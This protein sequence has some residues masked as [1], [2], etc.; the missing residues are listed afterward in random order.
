M[1]SPDPW[2]AP[3]ELPATTTPDQNQ[4]LPISIHPVELPVPHEH[5][6]D[7]QSPE[8]LA[9][10]TKKSGGR[11]SGFDRFFPKKSL[12]WLVIG[13]LSWLAG[14]WVEDSAHFILSQFQIHWALGILF[15]LLVL[16]TLT[17]A[18]IVVITEGAGIVRLRRFDAVQQ[19]MR[20]LWNGAGHGRGVDLTLQLRRDFVQ[21]TWL[22]PAWL[23]FHGLAQ[24]HHDDRELLQLLS[25]TVYAKLDHRCYEIIVQ[26]GSATALFSTLSPFVWLDSLF[27][28]WQNLK[29]I[30]EIAACYGLQPGWSASLILAKKVTLGLFMAGTVDLVA[31]KVAETVGG[32]AASVLLAQVGKGM[33]NALF[34]ARVGLAAMNRCRMVP[35]HPGGQPSLDHLRVELLKTVKISLGRSNQEQGPDAMFQPFEK[36]RE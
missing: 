32:Q 6:V 28:L 17:A 29:M 14:I 33:A 35:F 26:H 4:E 11:Y 3:V 36:N 13:G 9:P 25:R 24:A 30:R 19:D 20:Q 7:W 2:Q 22:E 21:E 15:G 12:A 31:D 23:E 16:T 18:L 1:N 5:T 27:F 34:T 10:D 8:E